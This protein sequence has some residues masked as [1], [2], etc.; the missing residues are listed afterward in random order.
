MYTYLTLFLTTIYLAI[1]SYTD[2]K[3]RFVKNKLTYSMTALGFLIHAIQSILESN[4]QPILFSI[5]AAITA[6]ITVY[7]L[8]RLGVFA[9][10]DAKLIVGIAAMFPTHTLFTYHPLVKP[11]L[12]NTALTTLPLFWA[13]V[14]A[15]SFV[16]IAPFILIY[17]TYHSIRLKKIGSQMLSKKPFFDALI[18][19]GWATIAF[20]T[21][22]HWFISII[23]IFAL[24]ILNSKTK[25]PILPIALISTGLFLSIPLTL[26]VLVSTIL[27][28]Y[29]FDLGKKFYKITN[30]H[31]LSEQ[32]AINQLEEGDII[33]EEVFFENNK[34]I[35]RKHD[36]FEPIKLLLSNNKQELG[37]LNSRNWIANPKKA[38]GLSDTE[39][40]KLNELFKKGLIDSLTVKKS[41]PFT[42]AI[43]IGFLLAM[44][45]GD[46]LWL[47]IK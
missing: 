27:L 37:K 12:E 17:C 46:I 26:Q 10:G 14:T 36:F 18:L 29:I 39:L 11:L 33:A 1:A 6:Y 44:I 3:T 28:L 15:M 22:L 31:V 13:T 9:G 45:V 42:P 41:I 32:K 38:A 19:S 35:K 7:L 5:T 4:P 47:V 23:S 34:L 21:N 2:I 16:S 20:F 43:F 24:F 8:W 25:K 30:Q 40:E